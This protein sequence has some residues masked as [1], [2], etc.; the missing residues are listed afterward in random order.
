MEPETTPLEV[1]FEEL[2]PVSLRELGWQALAGGQ[3]L[4]DL[5]ARQEHEVLLLMTFRRLAHHDHV[6]HDLGK[7]GYMPDFSFL[8]SK[9]PAL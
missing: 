9:I 4:P 1:P 7:S 6:A 8:T 3:H 5:R 2:D